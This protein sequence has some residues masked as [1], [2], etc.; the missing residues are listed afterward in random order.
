ML[1]TMRFFQTL[2]NIYE[3]YTFILYYIYIQYIHLI[4][5]TLLQHVQSGEQIQKSQTYFFVCL[6]VLPNVNMPHIY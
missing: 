6:F 5:V 2:L 4:S 3:L 1:Y